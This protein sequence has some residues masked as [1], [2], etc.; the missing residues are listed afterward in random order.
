M[1]KG[2]YS[3]EYKYK[4]GLN[5]AKSRCEKQISQIRKDHLRSLNPT[6][7]KVSIPKVF[8]ETII[9]IIF[10]ESVIKII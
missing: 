9:D 8:S 1:V 3:Q 2:K 10:S 7:Y 4:I 5:L 6:P